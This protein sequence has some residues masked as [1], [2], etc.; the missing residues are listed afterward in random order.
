M[1]HEVRALRTVRS[2][3][4]TAIAYERI[5]VGLSRPTANAHPGSSH[6]RAFLV[7][8]GTHRGRSPSAD[9]R[10]ELNHVS[11]QTPATAQAR[12]STCVIRDPRI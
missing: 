5:Y 12:P 3:D 1:A 11:R 7:S 10:F 6:R 9:C 4:G 2:C 8:Q